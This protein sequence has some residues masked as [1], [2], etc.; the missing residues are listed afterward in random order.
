MLRFSSSLNEGLMKTL[1]PDLSLSHLPWYI[2]PLHH[3]TQS[4][5]KN[6]INGSYDGR[7]VRG[8]CSA[9]RNHNIQELGHIFKFI[10]Q[11]AAAMTLE[12]EV[13]EY[14]TRV[15]QHRLQIVQ[16]N[17]LSLHVW[18]EKMPGALRQRTNCHT[19]KSNNSRKLFWLGVGNKIWSRVFGK[20][21]LE[22][23]PQGAR[24]VICINVFVPVRLSTIL[25]WLIWL[26]DICGISWRNIEV[27][28]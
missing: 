6:L 4:Y 18:T 9:V 12:W 23:L 3:L 13:K 16:M 14:Q 25:R 8:G 22:T 17:P 24:I 20:R 28:D 11:K 10:L 5:K 21:N 27:T 1:W 2:L 26:I 19:Y 7:I 15:L